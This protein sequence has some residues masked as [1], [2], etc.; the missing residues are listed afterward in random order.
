MEFV[1]DDKTLKINLCERVDTNNAAS[2]ES[3]LL[4][5][6][7]E[8][9][10]ENLILDA[11][12]TTYISSAGLRVMLKVRKQEKNLTITNVKAE[13]YDV[14][15]M[16]G[17]TEMINVEKAFRVVSVDGCEVIGEGANSIVYRLSSDIIIK[18]YKNPDCIDEIKRERELA[19][20]AFVLGVPTAISYDVVKVGDTYGAVFELLESNSIAKRMVKDPSTVEKYL[21]FYVDLIKTIHSIEVKPGEMPSMKEVALDW[22]K[23]DMDYLPKEY[24]EKLLKLISEVP[25]DTTM[26]H[27]DYHVKN[28]MVQQDEPILID[29]D[30]ICYGN[31]I[32]E[33]GSMFN[34]YE[35]FSTLDKNVVKKFLGIDYETAMYFWNESLKRYFGT[36]DQAFI[37]SVKDKAAIVGYMRLVRRTA[38]RLKPGDTALEAELEAYKKELISRLDK[39]DTLVI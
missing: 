7:Q 6:M 30:T 38:R 35:G 19:K 21:N 5:I 31:K 10:H 24:G 16:T 27:G 13:V 23:F 15:E 26:L 8:N 34:A 2:V 28:V 4:K 25:D 39:I 33:F 36:D 32:F 20:K 17:F 18:V 29:M 11:E 37:D 9:K 22:A 3:E 14:F 1:L 12:K